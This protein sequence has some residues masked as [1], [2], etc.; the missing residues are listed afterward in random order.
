MLPLLLQIQ[1][2]VEKLLRSYFDCDCNLHIKC[3]KNAPGDDGICKY[4]LNKDLVL[5]QYR[6][7]CEDVGV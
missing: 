2:N 7:K 5:S 4:A 1:G 6:P 3:R